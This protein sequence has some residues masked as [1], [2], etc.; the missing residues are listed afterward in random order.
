MIGYNIETSNGIL[1][2]GIPWTRIGFSIPLNWFAGGSAVAS[3]MFLITF[4]RKRRR[5]IACGAC[6]KCGYDL[7]GNVSGVCPEC[8]QRVLG[9]DS[10]RQ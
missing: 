8:G 5:L 9:T 10:V 2:V 6:M 3:L 7:T 1:F 4:L